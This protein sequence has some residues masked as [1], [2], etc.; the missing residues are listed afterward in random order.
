MEVASLAA[1]LVSARSATQ[2]QDVQVGLLKKAV[3]TQAAA[4]ATLIDKMALPLA[5]EGRLGTLV[6]T[7]A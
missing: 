6:N 4:A 1:A 3:D 7:Y 5:T 2:M